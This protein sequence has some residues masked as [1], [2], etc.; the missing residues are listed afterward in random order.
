MNIKILIILA[1]ELNFIKDELK[2]LYSVDF[3]NVEDEALEEK[4][5]DSDIQIVVIDKSIKNFTKELYEKINKEYLSIYFNPIKVNI[6]KISPSEFNSIRDVQSFKQ[7]I[8]NFKSFD[9]EQIKEDLNNKIKEVTAKKEAELRPQIEST[10]L[11]AI[12]IKEYFSIIDME[13]EDLK[14]KKEIYFVGE[15]GDGKTVLLQAIAL[16]LKGQGKDYTKLAYDY[17]EEI[18]ETM[19]L[20]TIDEKFPLEYKGYKNVKN[21]FAYGINRNKISSDNEDTKETSYSGLFDTPS[22]YKT[23]LLKDAETF[24]LRDDA[25]VNEFKEK[26]AFLMDEKFQIVKTDNGSLKYG[27]IKQFSMLSEGYKT[28]LI[29]LSD[30]LSRMM[31]NDKENEV[32]KLEDFQAIVLIDE[33]DLYLHPKWKYDFMN[34]LRIIF[35]KIQFIMTTHSLVTVL[36][37]SEDAVFYKVYKEEGETKIT[38]QIDDISYYTSDIL[39]SSPLFNMRTI[40][41]RAFDEKESS[42]KENLSSDDYVYNRIHKKIK[43]RINQTPMATD[44]DVD[45][46]LDDAFDEEFGE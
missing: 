13:I 23:T 14:D 38:G 43:E 6:N 20:S 44:K 25:L 26:I 2:E 29:W 45:S 5:L 35:P 24:L 12:K 4:I 18:E 17:I 15:N 40:K 8:E 46:W 39:M 36:G 1:K 22:I 31:E 33:V 28:T 34:K 10:Y 3:I 37:A 7:F 30:L 19:K 16:A 27:E 11:E 41:S 21:L 9:I 42:K 32:E